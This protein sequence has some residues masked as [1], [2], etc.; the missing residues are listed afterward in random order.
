[1]QAQLIYGHLP[2]AH[3]KTVATQESSGGCQ[4]PLTHHQP[5]QDIAGGSF[6]QKAAFV[7]LAALVSLERAVC[8]QPVNP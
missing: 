3:K 7:M 6:P 4:A 2:T 8:Y 5:L 1:M